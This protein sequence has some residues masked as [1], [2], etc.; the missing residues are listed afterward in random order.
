MARKHIKAA[1][2]I[3]P[4]LKYN[5]K[6][7]ARL[8]N[9]VMKCGKKMK[10]EKIVYTM[11]ENL[12]EESK[13]EPL[14]V[15]VRAIENVKPKVEVRS[16]R[17]G[18]ANYQVP[19]EVDQSRQLALALR[20]ILQFAR[21]RAGVPMHKALQMEIMDAYNNQGNAIRRRDDVYKMAQAN[22]AFA[23]YK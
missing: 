14:E 17:I 1:A 15:L 3:E 21:S 16:R 9:Q 12:K 2:D 13:Q 4:D 23:H 20:W 18:G 10:A 5:N 19:V 7:L 8:I 6:L 11:L 22:K